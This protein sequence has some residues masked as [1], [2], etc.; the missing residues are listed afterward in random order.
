MNHTRIDKRR[1]WHV[2]LIQRVQHEK[3][4]KADDSANQLVFE[5]VLYRVFDFIQS[6]TPLLNPSQIAMIITSHFN[7]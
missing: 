4:Q 7:P 5:S 1:H 2:Y 6:N 3:Q